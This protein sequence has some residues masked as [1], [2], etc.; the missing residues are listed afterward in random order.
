MF[1]LSERSASRLVGV[2]TDLIEVIELALTITNIDF[3]IPE[4]GG[5]RTSEQ[6]NSLFLKKASQLDGYKNKSYHQTGNAF[7]V[8]A[9]VDGKA[10]WNEKHLTHVA[11]AILQAASHEG[12]PLNWGGF[13]TGFK[14]MPHFEYRGR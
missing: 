10:S 13:W 7:D 8:F 1:K 2:K 3:G 11:A 4:F 12:V 9:Y 5:F 6:Q 14:D